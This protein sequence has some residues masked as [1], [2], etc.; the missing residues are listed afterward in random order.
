VIVEG[1]RGS[2]RGKAA[3]LRTAGVFVAERFNDI[4]YGLL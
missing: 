4:L 2:V 3:A 1:R